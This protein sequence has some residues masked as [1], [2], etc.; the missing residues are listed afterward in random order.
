[1]LER[2]AEARGDLVTY[3]AALVQ[4]TVG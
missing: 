3:A 4:G 2:V 1:V